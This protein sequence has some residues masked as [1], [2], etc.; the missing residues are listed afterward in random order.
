[1]I[2][3]TGDLHGDIERLKNPKL[4]KLKKG[5]TL[6]VLGDFGFLWNGG[7]KEQKHLKWLGKR[8][9]QL[10]FLEGTHDNLD[11]ISQYPEEDWCGGKAR[12]ISGKLKHLSRGSVFSIEGKKLFVFGGGESSDMD[13]RE[14]GVTW[15]KNELPTEEEV[16]A[17]KQVLKE[18]GNCVDY[19]LSHDAPARV[20][21]FIDMDSNHTNWLIAF[22]DELCNTLTYT[23]WYFGSLHQ[24][25]SYTHYHTGVYKEVLPLE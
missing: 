2:Y 19:V 21:S 9:Y 13:V 6:I 5:D 4:K 18:N 11:L 7:K 25:K 8:R 22:F 14:E 12:T 24:D 16:A 1:M 15:W 10:L 23:K 3:V 17:A 20:H